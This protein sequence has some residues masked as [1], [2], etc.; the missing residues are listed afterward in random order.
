MTMRTGD[1]W[2]DTADTYYKFMNNDNFDGSLC[3]IHNW[4]TFLYDFLYL[5]ID[6]HQHKNKYKYKQTNNSAGTE[7]TS[8]KFIGMRLKSQVKVEEYKYK[9]YYW[10]LKS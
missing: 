8:W 7:E 6:K 2:L 1:W 10:C 5:N 3:H 4:S 9:I